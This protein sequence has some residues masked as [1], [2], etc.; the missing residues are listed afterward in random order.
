MDEGLRIGFV[1]NKDWIHLG[2]TEPTVLENLYTCITA[3]YAKETT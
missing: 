2:G 3:M 1:R